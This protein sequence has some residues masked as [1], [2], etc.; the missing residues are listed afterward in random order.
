VEPVSRIEDK[1]S[2]GGIT[3]ELCDASLSIWVY[4]CISKIFTLKGSLR[5]QGLAQYV[6]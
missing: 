1:R 3:S 6:F 2:G 5:Q 4:G